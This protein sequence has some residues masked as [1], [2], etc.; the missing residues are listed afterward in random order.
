[1]TAAKSFRERLTAR[2]PLLGVWMK[3]PSPIVADVFGRTPLDCVCLDAEHA[4]FDRMAIDGCVASLRASGMAALVRPQSAT[5]EHLQSALDCGAIGIVAPHIR[6]GAEAESLS[7]ACRFGPGGRGFAGSTR[8]AGYG[9]LTIA[10]ALADAAQ[11]TCVIAQIEDVEAVDAIDEI[12][13]VEG[14]D[15]LFVGR[16][17]L[18]VGLGA[19]SPDEKIVVDAVAAICAAGKKHGRATGMFVSN[20]SEI[21][22]WRKAGASLFILKSD[23]AFIVEGATALRATFDAA[24]DAVSG[25]I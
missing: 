7:R 19:T 12:A 2:D 11:S 6:S 16:I 8:A 22:A 25:A 15:C 9:G 21:E 23:H 13:R 17:D 18:T 10:S 14:V 4:P 24:T 3:T 5:P 20:L 1:M